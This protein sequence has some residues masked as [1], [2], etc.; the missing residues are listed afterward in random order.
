MEE[1]KRRARGERSFQRYGSRRSRATINGSSSSSY[2][3]SNTGAVE[4]PDLTSRFFRCRE[5]ILEIAYDI[6]RLM[7]SLS[8][9]FSRLAQS[10]LKTLQH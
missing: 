6:A 3:P 9:L 1:V 7:D 8:G 10:S 2:A 5:V 4:S